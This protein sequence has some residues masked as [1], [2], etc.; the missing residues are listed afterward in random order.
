MDEPKQMAKL[1]E[2]DKG[3]QTWLQNRK[4]GPQREWVSMKHGLVV[5]IEPSGLKT[6]QARLRLADMEQARRV[7]LGA[8]PAMSVAEAR[9]EIAKVKSA[10]RNGADPS[11][12]RRRAASGHRQLTTLSDLIV[13]YLSRRDGRVAPKTM[14]LEREQLA[15]IER[16]LG[17]RRFNDIKPQEIGAQ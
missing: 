12:E 2:S 5:V 9:Q 14:K 15:V 6:F 7:R 17:N 8:F 16:A 10:A 11:L 3:W 4:P 13:E 1:P